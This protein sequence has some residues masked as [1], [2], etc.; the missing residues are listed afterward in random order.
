VLYRSMAEPVLNASR[1]LARIGQGVAAV[2][3]HVHMP[4]P[5]RS[6]HPISPRSAEGD[7]EGYA[8]SLLLEIAWN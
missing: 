7:S 3:E 6:G 5:P 4:T 8:V 2:P 1:A